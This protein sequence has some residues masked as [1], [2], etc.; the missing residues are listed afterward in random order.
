VRVLVVDD[1]PQT[2]GLLERGLREA[3]F[4]VESVG[5]AEAAERT[6]NSVGF[7]A[8]IL[9]VI[10]P[11]E[12]GL[13]V[14][15]RLRARGVDTP[16]V[17]LTGRNR[18]DDRIR[19]LDA[20]ADDYLAKPFAFGEL[21]ARLHAITRRG[22][23]LNSRAVLSYGAVELDQRDGSVTVAGQVVALSPTE[24]RLLEYLLLR[25]ERIVPRDE[26]TRH[27]W[28]HAT[29]DS[30]VVEVYINYLRKKLAPAGSLVRTV[31]GRGYMLI[32]ETR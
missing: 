5:D 18:L 8:I 16:I 14:C 25:S 23:T 13:T 15:R 9:D 3:L 24:Y 22:R 1:D 4:K 10:L 21:V 28:A 19:G 12:D 26:L 2:R 29:A 17:M 27:V 11:G 31:R 30:N 32:Q 20:G 6:A 7:D